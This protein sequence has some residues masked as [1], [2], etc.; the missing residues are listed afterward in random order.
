MRRR[1]RESPEYPLALTVM[2]VSLDVITPLVKIA[3]CATSYVWPPSLVRRAADKEYKGATIVR[4]N[5]S[6]FTEEDIVILEK[7]TDMYVFF[8]SFVGY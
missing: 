7:H 8:H 3:V 5:Q 6:V 1:G 2:V 4:S